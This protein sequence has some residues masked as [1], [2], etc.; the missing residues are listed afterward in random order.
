MDSIQQESKYKFTEFPTSFVITAPDRNPVRVELMGYYFVVNGIR[1]GM[2]NYYELSRYVADQLMKDYVPPRL[3]KGKNN[4]DDYVPQ[5]IRAWAPHQTAKAIGKRVHAQWLRLLEKVDPDVRTVQKAIFAATRHT[6]DIATVPDLYQNPGL[7][8]DIINYPAAA[9]AAVHIGTLLRNRQNRAEQ[10][11][12]R[13]LLQSPEYEALTKL[14]DG[15]GV[16]VDIT[17]RS[18]RRRDNHFGDFSL[19]AQLEGLANWMGLYSPTG[20]LYRSLN[21]TLMNL[22]GGVPSGY[23][24]ELQGLNLPRPVT[25]R[26]E[27]NFILAYQSG[28]NRFADEQRYI[29]PVVLYAQAPQIKEAMGRIGEYTHNEFNPRRSRDIAFAARFLTDYHDD[30]TGNIV[31]LTDKAIN[32]H[33]YEQEVEAQK[34]IDKLGKETLATIP[35]IPLPDQPEIRFLATVEEICQEGT[36]MG[37]C[38]AGYAHDAVKGHCYLFQ[39]IHNGERA[40]VQ[41]NMFGQVVQSHGPHNHRNNAEAWGRQTLKRWGARFPD[42][43]QLQARCLSGSY[44]RVMPELQE[45][46]R[47]IPEPP[48]MEEFPF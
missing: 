43:D 31:G 22:P 13:L 48:Y 36:E 16:T 14:A 3:N 24:V 47:Q 38:I 28:L 32:W 33:R 30:H 39:V 26:L 44:P 23:L 1:L 25:N 45:G 29:L 34:Q 17:T 8:R 6:A 9:A 27:L 42:L 5:W 40:S 41:V 7:V 46:E 37:H 19:D 4:T 21:R 2:Y 20:V 18:D 11:C 35:P 15:L 12:T 10:N